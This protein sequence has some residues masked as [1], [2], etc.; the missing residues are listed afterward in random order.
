LRVGSAIDTDIRRYAF[1]PVHF[2]AT[3]TAAPLRGAARCCCCSLRESL[4][5]ILCF[6]LLSV[7]VVDVFAMHL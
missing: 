2:A 1:A 5:W 4:C 7:V 3:A 6:Y